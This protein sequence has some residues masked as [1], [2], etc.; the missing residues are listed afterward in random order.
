MKLVV[1]FSSI[2]F[3]LF[4]SFHPAAKTL[5]VKLLLEKAKATV[6]SVNDASALSGLVFH[7]L[8]GGTCYLLTGYFNS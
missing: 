7:E 8:Q 4:K 3:T 1:K 2:F 5:L 6:E